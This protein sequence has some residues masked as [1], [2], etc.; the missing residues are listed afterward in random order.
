MTV[1][2]GF[3]QKREILIATD[4]TSI[5]DGFVDHCDSCKVVHP[6]GLRH[7][8]LA[9]TGV[10]SLG[11]MLAEEKGLFGKEEEITLPYFVN[12]IIPRIFTYCAQSNFFSNKVSDDTIHLPISFLFATSDKL[13]SVNETGAVRQIEGCTAL[14][15]GRETAF[16][17]MMATKDQKLSLEERGI[18]AVKAAIKYKPGLGYPIYLASNQTEDI[19]RLD[20]DGKRTKVK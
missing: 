5:C 18:L 19:I 7:C 4:G 3:K 14:G 1:I 9:V 20:E 6:Y 2:A 15:S 13:F 10:R 16:A 12:T 8:L 17:N 11:N